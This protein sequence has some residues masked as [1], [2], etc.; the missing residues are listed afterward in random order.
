MRAQAAH[1]CAMFRTMMRPIG[2]LVMSV[3]TPLVSQVYVVDSFG[4]PGSSFTTIDS[5]VAS[6]PDGAVVRVRAGQYQSFVIDQKSLTVLGE[7]GA[8]VTGFQGSIRVRNL[9]ANQQVTIRGMQ[10]FSA[11]GGNAFVLQDNA[12]TVLLDS[13][14]S[15]GGSGV[16]GR[17]MVGNCNDVRLAGCLL[18]PDTA[19]SCYCI[20]SSVRI[21]QSA[22][23]NGASALNFVNCC[24]ELANV[25][26]A[27]GFGSPSMG[28]ANSDV[29]ILA[30]CMLRSGALAPVISGIGNLRLDPS[31]MLTPFAGNPLFGPSLQVTSLVMPIVA[32]RTEPAGGLASASLI[33]PAGGIGAVWLGLPA[34]PTMPASFADAIVLQPGSENLQA[35]GVLGPTLTAGYIVP[36][37]PLLLGMRVTW[38]GASLDAT[39]GAQISNGVTYV[40]W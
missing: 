19:G 28:L 5:A 35:L 31:A 3:V 40:H 6:V 4:G 8:W 15:L 39:Q 32:A 37:L 2:L 1:G 38:Q 16:G 27:S 22:F 11:L 29:R 24:V 36:P 10:V 12:G 17:L 7:P 21:A 25:S 33:G 23:V 14:V 20:D 18:W 13:C 9:Q 26:A 34:L 30:G